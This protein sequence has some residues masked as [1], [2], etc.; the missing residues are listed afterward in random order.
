M[1]LADRSEQ[2]RFAHAFCCAPL[3]I[4]CP[5]SVLLPRFSWAEKDMF[6]RDKQ[7]G[8]MGGAWNSRKE[9]YASS[10]SA[11]PA[12]KASLHQEAALHFEASG[13]PR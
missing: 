12:D 13:R 9:Q 6:G 1:N 7:P 4:P 2:Q 10:S 8:Q 3:A 5:E 11:R